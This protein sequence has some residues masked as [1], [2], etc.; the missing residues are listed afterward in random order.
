MQGPDYTQW[1]G[2]YELIT[3]LEELEEMVEEK[4]ASVETIVGEGEVGGEEAVVEGGEAESDVS[5]EADGESGEETPEAA[6]T[7]EAGD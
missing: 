7:A 4:L 3:D 6:A 5:A 2:A 1:H